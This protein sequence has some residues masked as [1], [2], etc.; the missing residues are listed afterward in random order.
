MISTPA[1]SLRDLPGRAVIAGIR[2]VH[3]V[4]SPDAQSTRAGEVCQGFD[5]YVNESKT[6]QIL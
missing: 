4:I 6:N 3:Y 5:N 1:R 2:L